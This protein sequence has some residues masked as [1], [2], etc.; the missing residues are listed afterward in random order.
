M[1]FREMVKKVQL[2]SGFSDSE[3]QDALELMV[4]S[5]AERLTEDERKDFAAQLPHE[6]K[7]IALAAQPIPREDKKHII[8]EFMGRE[9]IGESRAKKQI[10]CAWKAIKE[11]ISDGEIRDMKAQ[12]P[13]SMTAFLH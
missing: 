9:N 11:A 8:E 10:L 7:E 6:L 4:E 13:D 12:L 1:K 3:S 2:D 5:L